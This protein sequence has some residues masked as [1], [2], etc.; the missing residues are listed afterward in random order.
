MRL[1]FGLLLLATA[2]GPAAPN[3]AAT[4]AAAP[5]KAG[6]SKYP[7]G[8][9]APGELPA[10]FDA[11]TYGSQQVRDD[12]YCAGLTQEWFRQ[13][14]LTPQN[15]RGN[16]GADDAACQH[17]D[18]RAAADWRKRQHDRRYVRLIIPRNGAKGYKSGEPRITLEA[19][20]ARQKELPAYDLP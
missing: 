4:G 5:P 20:L 16:R 19:C 8:A 18:G 2:C 3:D 15:V 1:L 17:R 10:D 14:K 7:P 6:F 11:A 9:G 13:T 12:F